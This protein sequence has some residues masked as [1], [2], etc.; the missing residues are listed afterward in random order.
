MPS[1]GPQEIHLLVV[2]ILVFVLSMAAF[3]WFAAARGRTRD[4]NP[5]TTQ[6][7]HPNPLSP[8][9]QAAADEASLHRLVTQGMMEELGR[10]RQRPE[11]D[12][13]R[14][15]HWDGCHCIDCYRAERRLANNR[16]QPNSKPQRGI[17]RQRQI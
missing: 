6:S 9:D 5:S 16:H 12:Q 7:S 3:L 1:S 14:R 10:Q 15:A 17:S 2:V 11:Y 13:P 4:E 8:E